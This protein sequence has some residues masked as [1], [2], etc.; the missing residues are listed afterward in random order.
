MCARAL[1]SWTQRLQHEDVT[2]RVKAYLVTLKDADSSCGICDPL[3]VGIDG[4]A[5]V[6]RPARFALKT[7]ISS[8]PW[9]LLFDN[10]E[11][12]ASVEGVPSERALEEVLDR[13]SIREG[14]VA[15][16]FVETGPTLPLPELRNR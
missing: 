7:G 15:R 16:P 11:L 9:T 4:M 5:T 10:G 14:I 13:L 6:A 8:V 1:R 2:S 12:L 3:P